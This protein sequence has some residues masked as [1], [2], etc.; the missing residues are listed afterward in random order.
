MS[1]HEHESGQPV[2][3]RSSVE[4]SLN[5]KREAQVRVKVYAGEE[6][7]AVIRAREIATAQFYETL[8]ACGVGD[9]P[10]LGMARRESNAA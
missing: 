1:T 10:R 5:A 2:E 9:E 3:Q 6:E 4:I 8:K 7:D